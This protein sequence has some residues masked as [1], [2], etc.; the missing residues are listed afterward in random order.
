MVLSQPRTVVSRR[1][2]PPPVGREVS[3][4]DLIYRRVRS[5]QRAGAPKYNQKQA[6]ARLKKV[7]EFRRSLAARQK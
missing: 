2:K 5:A 7:E 6:S 3:F 1:R 4:F